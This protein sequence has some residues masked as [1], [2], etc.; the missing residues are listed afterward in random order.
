M[1]SID[2]RL[3]LI[4]LIPL[5]LVS[6][7]VKLFGSAIHRRFETIQAQLSEMS[8]VTQETLSGVRV[9]RAYGQEAVRDGALRLANEEYVAPQPRP[10]P[11]AGRVLSEPDAAA[12][13]R[14]AARAVARQPRRHP[15]THHGRR[16]RR[17]QRLPGDAELADDRLRL[18]HEHVP[19][20]HRVV[21]AHARGARRA[22]VDRRSAVAPVGRSD[23]SAGAS[24]CA[25][26]RVPRPDL[27]YGD[28][29]R[30][31]RH[32]RS[33]I[34]P[35]RRPPS[36]A[37]PGSGKSTLL[38]PAAAAAGAAAGHG[39]RRRRRRPRPAAGDAAR[40][41]GF[42]PQEPFL[43][44]D[45]IAANIAFAPES[46]RCSAEAALAAVEHAARDRAARQ[47][48]RRLSA[49]LRH[50]RRRAR[51]HAVGRPEAAHRDRARARD[52]DPRILILDDALSAV[53]TYTEEEI[54]ARL[55]GVMRQRTS[56][57][58]V[59]S[60]L[61]GARRR[62]DSRARRRARSS[63]AARTTSSSRTAA[64]TRSCI[65]SSCSKRSWS[66]EG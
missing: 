53:D 6:V 21:E 65:G 56:I 41:I 10:D 22:A 34:E 66:E 27:S 64:C 23:R 24:R 38:Q 8:A 18:G 58:V 47:G 60:R 2:T 62:S 48:P 40:R 31:R 1:L 49:R 37:R 52:V 51:H 25:A 44:S 46:R 20:R 15:G 3:T 17:V 12:G 30:P 39:V 55:R 11:P 36:S 32:R 57:I 43:F 28:A 29:P 16:A 42:V 63:S 13:P 26:R 33:T 61:D 7:S 45:T 54:L 50:R 14:R 19:A 5:P 59:A 4:A 9:V 35:G